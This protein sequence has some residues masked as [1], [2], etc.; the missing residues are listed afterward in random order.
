MRN[1]FYD[2]DKSYLLFWNKFAKFDMPKITL[3]EETVSVAFN[4]LTTTATVW[5]KL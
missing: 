2:F 4:L 5:L 3:T 1:Y